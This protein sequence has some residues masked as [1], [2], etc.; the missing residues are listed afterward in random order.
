M[1]GRCRDLGWAVWLSWRDE[2]G[3]RRHLM[4]LPDML[5][6]RENWRR[7]RIWLRHSAEGH[8]RLTNP[9]SRSGLALPC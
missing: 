5:D 1:L 7:L 6:D 9:F 3:L 2:S 4:L 8:G